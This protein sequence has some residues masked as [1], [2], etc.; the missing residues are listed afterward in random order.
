MLGLVVLAWAALGLADPVLRTLAAAWLLCA[1]HLLQIARRERGSAAHHPAGDVGFLPLHLATVCY[2]LG[3]A[4]YGRSSALWFGARWLTG[5]VTLGGAPAGIWVPGWPIY[6]FG[7]LVAISALVLHARAERRR[8]PSVGERHPGRPW[9]AAACA[10]GVLVSGALAGSAVLG[11]LVPIS[12]LKI[13]CAHF[14]AMA[15]V[16]GVVW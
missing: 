9:L 10:V 4:A 1:V 11:R 5:L 7:I 15:L 12:Q 14:G 3:L 2:A 13:S 8:A 16:G 6:A